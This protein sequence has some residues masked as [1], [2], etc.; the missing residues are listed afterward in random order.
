M[1]KLTPSRPFTAAKGAISLFSAPLIVAPPSEQVVAAVLQYADVRE[2]H[3]DGRVTLRFTAARLAREDMALLLGEACVRARD[4]SII[5]DEAECE[6]VRVIDLAPLRAGR[7]GLDQANLYAAA[8]KR[9]LR[10]MSN[11]TLHAAA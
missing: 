8:R 6:M 7:E 2:E 10:A 1:A 3:D 5:W 9:S 11:V 4:I